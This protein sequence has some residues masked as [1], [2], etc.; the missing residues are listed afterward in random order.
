MLRD[1]PVLRFTSGR[2]RIV[3]IVVTTPWK[4]IMRSVVRRFSRLEGITAHRGANSGSPV[5]ALVGAYDSLVGRS[6]YPALEKRKSPASGA[7]F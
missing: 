3:C 1:S 6:R 7:F 5:P 2:L 4:L